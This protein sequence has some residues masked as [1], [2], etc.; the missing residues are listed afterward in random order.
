MF[1]DSP[2]SLFQLKSYLFG[3]EYDHAFKRGDRFPNNLNDAFK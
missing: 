2:Y 3:D 1:K